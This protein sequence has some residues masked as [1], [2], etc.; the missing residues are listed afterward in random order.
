MRT[1]YIKNFKGEVVATL[2]N[3]QDPIAFIRGLGGNHYP[4][5]QAEDIFSA[6]Y[7]QKRLEAIRAET[8]RT[9]EIA[10]LYFA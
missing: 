4:A 3:G 9:K 8:D 2:T 7:K 5:Y 6:E 10:T 1:V